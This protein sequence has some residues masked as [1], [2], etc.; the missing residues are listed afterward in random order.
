MKNIPFLTVAFMFL[1]HFI[2]LVL[3]LIQRNDCLLFNFCG[4][5]NL[6]LGNP[7]IQDGRRLAIM[8]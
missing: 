6:F 1:A 7:E 2:V 8:M 4:F 5:L 3:V